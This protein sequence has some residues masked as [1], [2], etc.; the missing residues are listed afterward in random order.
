MTYATWAAGDVSITLNALK[1]APEK[2]DEPTG[3]ATEPTPTGTDPVGTETTGT[4]STGTVP[5][6]TGGATDTTGTTASTTAPAKGDNP[7]TG[8]NTLPLLAGTLLLTGSAAALFLTRKAS[9][10]R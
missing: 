4:D 6:G 5:T 9:R 1:F 2:S 8:D 3:S 10:T 7:K